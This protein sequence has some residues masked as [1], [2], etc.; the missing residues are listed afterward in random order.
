VSVCP[1]EGICAMI[2]EPTRFEE[3][4]L[5]DGRI[6]AHVRVVSSGWLESAG[7]SGRSLMVTCVDVT[8]IADLQTISSE[9]NLLDAE[10]SENIRKL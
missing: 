5:S 7:V 9:V 10:L 8:R 4:L 2:D 3:D 1:T 6:V